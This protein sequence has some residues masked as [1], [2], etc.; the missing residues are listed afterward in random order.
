MKYIQP[1]SLCFALFMILTSVSY[2]QNWT[3]DIETAK[4]T[5]ASESKLI[6]LSF[7]GSDWCS[8]CIRLEK[9]LFDS[10]EFKSYYADHYVLL[11]ADFPMKKKNKLSPEQTAHNEKLAEKY[12]KSGTFPT[13]YIL[14]AAGEVV[15]KLEHPKDTAAEYIAQLT[16]LTK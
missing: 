10:E 8:N 16:K 12:N 9:T 7:S 11:K 1:R 6:L 5:A 15:G 13:V 3:T 4:A 2:A 14:N